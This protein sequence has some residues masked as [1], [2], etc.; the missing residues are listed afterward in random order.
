VSTSSVD[1]DN[2]ILAIG[3]LTVLF[4]SCV[5]LMV[6]PSLDHALFSAMNGLHSPILDYWWLSATTLGD[7]LILSIILGG[8][9]VVNPRVTVLGLLLILLST[10]V[11][12]FVKAFW[13]TLRPVSVLESVHVIGPLLRSGAFPSGH[14]ASVTAAGLAVLYY[15]PSVP[16]RITALAYVTLVCFS[17][18]FVGAHFPRDV[19]GGTVISLALLWLLSAT[20]W[21]RWEAAIGSAPD[22][23]KRSFRFFLCLE[24]LAVLYVLF[25]YGPRNADDPSI[26]AGVAVAVLIVLVRS[27]SSRHGPA[28]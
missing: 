6:Y 9:L 12:H 1:T 11:V 27:W 15:F 8:F 3:T 13:P 2:K 21:P 7:G 25:V 22:F 18:V 4:L 19:I 16:A 28:T 23:T 14:A 20:V 17:R 26:A 5:P 10:C 24:A